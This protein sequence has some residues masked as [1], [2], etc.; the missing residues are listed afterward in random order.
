MKKSANEI[1]N[2]VAEN[3]QSTLDENNASANIFI[4]KKKMHIIN[5]YVL[6][7]ISNFS[8]II[9]NYNL[10]KNEIRVVLKIL[11]LMQFGNLINITWTEVAKELNIEKSN[12]F[13]ILRRLKN[14][15]LIV[16][17][18]EHTFFN[19]HIACKGILKECDE[20][21]EQLLNISADVLT[22]D[23]DNE[24]TP[25]ITTKKIRQN[26]YQ[27]NMLKK[28]EE[29][30]DDEFYENIAKKTSENNPLND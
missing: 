13:K 27:K 24:F 17:I 28:N 30:F 3:L 15:E 22:K 19:P 4:S 8:K 2:L 6:L 20:N 7:F 16:R 5:P 21:S 25:S 14:T 18:N 12:F 26:N 23:F 11:E 29:I 10:T 9:D 1:L